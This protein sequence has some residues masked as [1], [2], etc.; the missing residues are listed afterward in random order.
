MRKTGGFFRQFLMALPRIIL[1]G[2]LGIVISKPLELKIFEKEIEKQL[3]V[4]INRNKTKLQNEIK[5]RYDVQGKFY[6]AG[7]DSIV[8]EAKRLKD[9][10]NSASL[11]LEKEIV[12]TTSETTTGKKGFGSNAK[13]KEEIKR[14]KQIAY[15]NFN[16]A[17]KSKLDSFE[18]LLRNENAQFEQELK[19]TEP[20][21][22][23]YNGFAA[24]I[25][26]LQE[27]GTEYKILGIASLFI[28]LLFILIEI[29]PVLVK[30]MMPKGPYDYLLELHEYQ[31]KWKNDEESKMKESISGAKVDMLRDEIQYLVK[32]NKERKG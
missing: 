11:D 13:R 27:L 30:L 22:D 2:V 23:K 8:N 24:R 17:N 29:S 32:K 12:G 18:T 5:N 1:A 4:I 14:Q 10:Y 3:N 20:V 9:E 6:Y 7:R 15:E 21:E 28:T 26:A 31:F 25:Q 16:S 19:N